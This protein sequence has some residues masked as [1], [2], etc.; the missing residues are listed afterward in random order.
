MYLIYSSAQPTTK[1]I[2]VLKGYRKSKQ[3]ISYLNDIFCRV[4]FWFQVSPWVKFVTALRAL[5]RCTFSEQQL[6]ADIIPVITTW[7]NNPVHSMM[8]RHG[9][10][11]L[12]S[13]ST[14]IIQVFSRNEVLK[15]DSFHNLRSN[16]NS[17]LIGF[18]PGSGAVNATYGTQ[19]A[20][21][22][23]WG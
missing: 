9:W 5:S 18:S 16:S 20:Y 21:T 17:Y 10:S 3:G 13:F 1:F 11:L 14:D 19:V 4:K 6:L 23:R 22:N 8:F 15:L 2:I 7:A 12:H